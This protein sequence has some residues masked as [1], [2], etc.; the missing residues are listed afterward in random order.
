[1]FGAEE[2]VSVMK[3]QLED[4]QPILVQ[5]AKE[6][7]ELLTRIDADKVKAEQTRSLVEFEEAIA[8]VKAEE[9]RVIKEDC[10][11]ELAVVSET[12]AFHGFWFQLYIFNCSSYDYCKM[13]EIGS[14]SVTGGSSEANLS[15]I[16]SPLS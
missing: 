5:T 9:A 3:A 2:Q 10:E 8:N 16:L 14:S 7:N 15:Y 12:R 6:T 4:L 13:C 11:A 1:M